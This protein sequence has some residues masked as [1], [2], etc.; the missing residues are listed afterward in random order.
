MEMIPSLNIFFF[1]NSF[2]NILNPTKLSAKGKE[3]IKTFSEMQG[4]KSL[5]PILAFSE[6]Y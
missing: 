6:S 3:R 5:P 1:F 2:S 4:F